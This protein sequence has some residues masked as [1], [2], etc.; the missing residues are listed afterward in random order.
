MEI[1]ITDVVKNYGK[2]RALD[3]I[4]LHIGS[5]MFG[6]LGPNGAGKTTLMKIITTLLRPTEGQVVVN[7]HNVE[8]EPHTVRQN[9]GY[10]PQDFGFYKSLN[11]YQLLD[12]IGVM[13][14]MPRAARKQ[15]VET[16]LHQVNLTHDAKRRIG[17]YSGGMKQRLG[18][19]QALLGAPE[20]L[21]VDEPTAGLDPEERIRFRNLLAR[22][23]GQRTV[24]LSTHIVADIEA[25]SAHVAVLNRGAVVFNGTPADLIKLAQGKVWEVEVTP[26]EYEQVER[27]ATVISSR[28][29]N[30]SM[31]LRVVAGE[32]PLGRGQAVQ[33]ALEDGYV[34]VMSK[35]QP[36]VEVTHA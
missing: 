1:Q 19:A 24:I 22:L 28:A 32:N 33:P 4:S 14:N 29:L 8:R 12:Y 20:L 11:A 16:V 31:Q 17:G 21:V 34:A 7:N 6:L 2:V 10:L 27:Q 5:G 13:K 18:I 26:A 3:H 25:S 36:A 35:A 9:L 30:G 15:Q 23:S